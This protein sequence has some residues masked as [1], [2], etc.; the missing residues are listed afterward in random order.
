VSNNSIDTCRPTQD[1][2]FDEGLG[3]Q[4]EQ[5][6]TRGSLAGGTLAD[7]NQAVQTRF[8]DNPYEALRVRVE[9]RRTG[10]N[11]TVP[12]PALA[13]VSRNATVKSRSRPRA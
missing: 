7:Q 13:S 9:I 1:L 5:Y 6:R 8:F 3:G 4:V 12:T 10:C 2:F 11:L